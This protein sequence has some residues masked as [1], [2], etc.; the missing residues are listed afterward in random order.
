MLFPEA[1][2]GSIPSHRMY[3]V[4]QWW[5][6]A[7]SGPREARR[8]PMMGRDG[9]S[10]RLRG[11]WLGVELFLTVSLLQRTSLFFRACFYF[12]LIADIR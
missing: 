7:A 1:R 2:A 10:A 12:R 3:L 5:M 4:A 11:D 9:R 6:V 8:P